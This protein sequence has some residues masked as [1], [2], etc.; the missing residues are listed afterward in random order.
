MLDGRPCISVFDDRAHEYD[1]WFD[2]NR[3]IYEA[4]IGALKRFMPREGLGLEVGIGTG[5]FA[6]PLN[7]QLGIDPA[8]QALRMARDRGILVCQAYGERLPFGRH[9][10]EIV[11]LVTVDPFVVDF[12]PLLKEAFRVLKPE[13]HAILGV[14]DRD[15]PL[16]KMYESQ[17]ESDPFYREARFHS[18]KEIEKDLKL[19]GFVAIRTCQ[20]VLGFPNSN[21]TAEKI[22]FRLKD[23]Y[24]NVRNGHGN[25]AF[26][27]FSARKPSPPKSL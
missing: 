16:G 24:L 2:E 7:I 6:L 11:L 15:S 20:T 8:Y 14:I 22:H 25:G 26:V 3:A 19:T 5:R 1:R 18:A 10:F 4:E 17:K 27:A 23:N 12:Q 13:G 21:A 9:Q